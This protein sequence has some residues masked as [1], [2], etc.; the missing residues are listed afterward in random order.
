MIWVPMGSKTD[1]SEGQTTADAAENGER[2]GFIMGTVFDVSQ[3]CELEETQPA[4]AEA[5]PCE[6]RTIWNSD[7]KDGPCLWMLKTRPSTVQMPGS[8]AAR[9]WRASSDMAL[10]CLAS[11]RNFAR[12]A[13]A[14]AFCSGVACLF[15]GGF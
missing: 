3:T 10:I 5:D 8:R 11:A 12:R 14:F 9:A 4:T 6:G 1:K 2:P 13:S 7:G 15:I